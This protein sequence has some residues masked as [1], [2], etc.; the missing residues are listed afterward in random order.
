[1][2]VA[3]RR[4]V[5]SA[6]EL[7]LH[8]R[9]GA[10]LHTGERLIGRVDRN[11]SWQPYRQQC[12][13]VAI[14]GT[15]DEIRPGRARWRNT[16]TGWVQEVAAFSLPQ[17]A[18]CAIEAH[19]GNGLTLLELHDPPV[20]ESAL[21]FDFIPDRLRNYRQCLRRHPEL[22][23]LY[24]GAPNPFEGLFACGTLRQ[25]SLAAHILLA[26]AARHFRGARRQTAH[27]DQGRSGRRD[28]W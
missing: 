19:L 6:G 8:H 24:F 27:R 9:I 21:R 26:V 11:V 1:M 14:G 15:V 5:S 20:I 7:G 12:I 18:P 23:E 2:A 22:P 16:F 25:Q 4:D 3:R 28:V 10:F 17:E 13:P